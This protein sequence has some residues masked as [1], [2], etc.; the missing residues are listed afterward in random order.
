MDMADMG[1]LQLM[2]TVILGLSVG[3]GAQWVAE[4]R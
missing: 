2:L 3:V 1:M 4:N